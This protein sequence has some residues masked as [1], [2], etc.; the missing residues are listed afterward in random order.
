MFFKS[1]V[2]IFGK[3]VSHNP[4]KTKI[5]IYQPIFTKIYGKVVCGTSAM[6]PVR[7]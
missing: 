2:K 3:K 5:F 6:A 7:S 1:L 4:K